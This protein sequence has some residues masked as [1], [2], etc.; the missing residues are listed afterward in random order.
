MIKFEYCFCTLTLRLF[1][2]K[3]PLLEGHLYVG[4]IFAQ[5]FSGHQVG[6][7][8]PGHLNNPEC[9]YQDK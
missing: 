3:H 1:D 9:V 4:K 6:L 7:S 5:S 2:I 8:N